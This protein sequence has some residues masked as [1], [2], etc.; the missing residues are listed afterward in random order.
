MLNLQLTPIGYKY[1]LTSKLGEYWTVCAGGVAHSALETIREGT[2]THCYK[3]GT[4][5]P[6]WTGCFSAHA[7]WGGWACSRQLNK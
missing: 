2:V 5:D 1:S 7:Q 4:G 3:P 6:C